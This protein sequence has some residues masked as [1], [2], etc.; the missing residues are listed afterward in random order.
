MARNLPIS[1][2]PSSLMQWMWRCY[3]Q[4]ALLIAACEKGLN[5]KEAQSAMPQT[6]Q[7]RVEIMKPSIV[8]ERVDGDAMP[9]WKLLQFKQREKNLRSSWDFRGLVFWK[10]ESW[11]Y[12][13]ILPP[14][15]PIPL[16][17]MTKPDQSSTQSWK[18]RICTSTFRF[19]ENA[20][21]QC[22]VAYGFH[23]TSHCGSKGACEKECRSTASPRYA[24][25]P[26]T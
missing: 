10:S 3:L 21:R 15:K 17:F 1:G 24:N 11:A 25:P 6:A 22:N 16:Q 9:W 19:S 7:N 20:L 18:K 13:P 23:A 8:F 4:I 12:G 14:K 26:G 5:V 2:A